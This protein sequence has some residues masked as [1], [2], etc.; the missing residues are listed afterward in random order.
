MARDIHIY[1]VYKP[2]GSV[3]AYFYTAQFAV[4]IMINGVKTF[5]DEHKYCNMQVMHFLNDN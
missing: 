1:S 4:N 2:V 5:T 3:W